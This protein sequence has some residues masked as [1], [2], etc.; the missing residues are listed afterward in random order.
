MPRRFIRDRDGRARK[1]RRKRKPFTFSPR[2][3]TKAPRWTNAFD[4]YEE[5]VLAYVDLMDA[6]TDR[7]EPLALPEEVAR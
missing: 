4:R 1:D 2:V 7:A 5:A 6:D 3:A